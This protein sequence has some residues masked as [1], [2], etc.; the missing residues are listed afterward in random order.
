MCL[1]RIYRDGWKTFHEKAMQELG[2]ALG[3]EL[4][5]GAA[6]AQGILAPAVRAW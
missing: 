2:F 5:I 3:S 1:I 4:A 6:E